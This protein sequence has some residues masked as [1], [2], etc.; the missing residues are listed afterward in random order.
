M[1]DL[2]SENVF[3]PYSLYI[4]EEL[5]VQG[6]VSFGCTDSLF[7]EY[8]ANANI[9]DGSCFTLVVSG[10]MDVAASNF[11]SEANTEDGSCEYPGCT[12]QII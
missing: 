8:D 4:V 11:D 3:A 6:P 1:L 2:V 7:V 10:C 9:D 5:N 12:D